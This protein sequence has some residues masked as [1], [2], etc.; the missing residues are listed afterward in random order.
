[1]SVTTHLREALLTALS[2]IDADQLADLYAVS[3]WLQFPGDDPRKATLTI[4]FNTERQVAA[5]AASSAAEARWNF[6]FW[7]QNSLGVVFDE[8]SDAVGATLIEQWARA[9]GYWYTDEDEAH[10]F[11]ASMA[12]VEPLTADFVALV[13]QVVRSLHDQGDIVRVLGRPVPVLIHELEYFDEV[14]L[15]NEAANP[16]ALVAP[17]AAWVRNGGE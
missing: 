3:L 2:R 16:T 4:G 10:H 9:R 17:F 14:A 13:A 1:M 15:Q 6:A 8:R 11:D 7:L 12:Q 5:S